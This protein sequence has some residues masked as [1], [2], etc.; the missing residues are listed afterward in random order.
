MRT[1]TEKQEVEDTLVEYHDILAGDRMDI[2]M[3]T[4]FAPKDKKAAYS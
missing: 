3:N 4:D 1:E 2:G